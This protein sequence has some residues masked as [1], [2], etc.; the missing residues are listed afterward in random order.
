MWK[1]YCKA[2]LHFNEKGQ[3]NI[4]TLIFIIIK[5]INKVLQH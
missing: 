5:K 4:L 1:T 2:D 3:K